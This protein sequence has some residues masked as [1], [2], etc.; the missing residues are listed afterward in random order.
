M[1]FPHQF[2]AHS[3]AA[4]LTLHEV[5]MKKLLIATM[6][7]VVGCSGSDAESVKKTDADGNDPHLLQ[8]Q[9][10]ALQSAKD[11]AK[12]LEAAAR[13]SESEIEKIQQD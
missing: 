8:T 9:A 7:V 6:L 1:I 13:R 3:L 2:G 10:D 12:S 11:A 4:D 5:F